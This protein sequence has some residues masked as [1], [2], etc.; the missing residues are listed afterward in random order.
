MRFRQ[1]NE[2]PSTF[3]VIIEP[4]EEAMAALTAFARDQSLTAS[5]VTAIGAFER[6]TLGYFD[7]DRR[8]YRPIPIEEQVEVLSLVGDIVGEG[9]D[10]KLHAHVV[11]S[12][13]D[14]S[15]RGG[16]LLEAIV[17]PT[18]EVVITETP[19]HLRRRFDPKTGVALIVT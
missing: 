19:T 14:G 17:W 13:S 8:D 6:A 1:V 18:L 9:E 12:G 5:Q 11:V 4:G 16:H 7:R 3:V 15:A 10:L 2:Q